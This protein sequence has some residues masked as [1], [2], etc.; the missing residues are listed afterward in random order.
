MRG[1]KW[2][3]RKRASC[4]REK[5]KAEYI[6]AKNK[7]KKWA[8][9]GHATCG[10]NNKWKTDVSEWQPRNCNSQ[11]RQRIRWRDEMRIFAGAGWS[12]LAWETGRWRMLGE[13]FVLQ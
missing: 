12:T 13:A 7:N 10:N 6:V 8:W 11:G 3:D 4:F 9:E 5:T 1:L 2:R